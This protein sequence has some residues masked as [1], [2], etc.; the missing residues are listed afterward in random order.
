M[1]DHDTNAQ[2]LFKIIQGYWFQ[3]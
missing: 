1:Q 2:R 3:Y